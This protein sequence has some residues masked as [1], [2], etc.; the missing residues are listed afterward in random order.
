[1]NGDGDAAPAGGERLPET[2][3]SLAR[4]VTAPVPGTV[5]ALAL[6][7]GMRLGPGANRQVIFGRNRPAVHVCLGEDDPLVSRHQ[8]TLT[9][10]AGQWWVGNHGRLPLR[11][12]GGRLLFTDEEPLPLATGYTPLFVR[13]SRHREHLLEIF[14]TGPDGETPVPMPSDVTRPPRTWVLTDEERLA[15]VVLGRRYLL[16]DL[17]PQPLTWQ[18]TAAHLSRIQP[19]VPWGPKRVEHLVSGVRNRLSRSG[20]PFLTREEV[21]EPVGNTL[22]DHLLR[23]LL[24][25]TTLVPPDLA[26][27]DA[28]PLP[29]RSG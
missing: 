28:G 16:H 11:L 21:G 27:L 15:L 9:H 24:L 2:H 23:E 22:N 19:G 1:M 29:D 7:G 17:R 4:G 10:R 13:G 25:S 8:G 6:T 26:L 3:G 20:V 14:V 18:D 12:A 5:F